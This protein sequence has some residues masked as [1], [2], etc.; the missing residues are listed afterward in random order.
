M[1]NKDISTV[2]VLIAD[3]HTIVREGLKQ[4]FSLTT[5]IVVAGEAVNGP[6]VCERIQRGNFDLILLDMSLPGINGV[7]LIALIRAQAAHLP[8]LVLSMHNEVQ[9]ARGALNAGA[10]GYLT[11]DSDPE[12]LVAAI[13][14][15]MEG[16]RVI[17]HQLAESM[18]FDVSRCP[19]NLPHH[20]LSKREMQI[21]CLLGGGMSVNEIAE[22]L[23][24]SNK[25]VSTHKA[26]LM[27]K[28]NIENNI[29]LVRYVIT[30]NLTG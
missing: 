17:D 2:R 21:L 27:Q 15:V 9:L 24:I 12:V 25:T 13:H 8:I 19:Q 20:Q 4:L 22:R 26:R 23:F 18:A 30:H 10:S 3:D 6:Q 29:E 14:K 11:K 16:G 28:M 1:T 7:E 5:D